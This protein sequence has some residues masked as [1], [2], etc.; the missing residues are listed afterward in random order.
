MKDSRAEGVRL[1]T[2]ALSAHWHTYPERFDW[3]LE[4]GF[5]VE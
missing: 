2:I 5:A 3:L 4:H 1:L